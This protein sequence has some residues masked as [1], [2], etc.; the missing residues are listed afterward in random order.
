MCVFFVLSFDSSC[1][2]RCVVQSN[3]T[4]KED[5]ARSI[6][7]QVFAALRYLSEQFPDQKI[8]HYDLKPANILFSSGGEVR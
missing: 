4:L 2:V 1:C 8:I 7:G 6:I 5:E 3:H